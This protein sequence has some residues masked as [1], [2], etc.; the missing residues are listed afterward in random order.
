M[1]PPDGSVDASLDLQ[2]H[3]K[4]LNTVKRAL[5][6]AAMLASAA[7]MSGPALAAPSVSLYGSV[8]LAWNVQPAMNATIHTSYTAGF[9]FGATTL[10]SNPAGT[11]P[12]AGATNADLTMDYG[13][14]QPSLGAT[15]ACNYNNAVGVSV[16]TNDN[17]GFQV[18]EYLDAALPVGTNLCAF[19]N[20]SAAFPVVPAAAI[21]QSA[22]AGVGPAVYA[23]GA[24]AASGAEVKVIAGGTLH[25]GGGG[26]GQPAAAPVAAE[27]ESAAANPAAGVD[28][29][30]QAVAAGTAVL[31]GEDLQ[32][33]VGPTAVSGAQSAIVTL[34]FVAN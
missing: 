8:K 3:V 1:T 34:Q 17:L 26:P 7:A 18:N 6:L 21:T 30:G 20:G 25:N 2:L 4:G 28:M 16:Q 5:A 22:R 9:A 24:C 10:L 11:C 29:M 19:P 23:A 32:L 15:V 13:N 31:A 14:I 33:N 12:A 27:Y